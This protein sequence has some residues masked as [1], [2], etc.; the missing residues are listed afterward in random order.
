MLKYEYGKMM[1]DCTSLKIGGP[2]FCWFEP[3]DFKGI[4]EAISVAETNKKALAF[5]GKGTNILARDEG[6]NGVAMRLGRGFN[7]IESEDNG[8]VRVG[9]AVFLSR[10]VKECAELGLMGCEF[11]S[12]IPA[13]FGGALFMNAGVRSIRDSGKRREIKDIIFD[14]DVLDLR[15]KKR[16]TLKRSDIEFSYRSSGLEGVCI[17]GGRIRLEKDRKSA[18]INR[19]DFFMERR[20]GL[21]DL[22]FPSAGSVFRN[23]QDVGPA[24]RLIEGC[25]LKGYRVGKAEFSAAHANIIVNTGG[26][27][28]KDVFDLID[29]AKKRVKKRF[30]IELELEL[31]VI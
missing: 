30:G 9:S 26:A 22:G 2:V 8:L 24:G 20:I 3:E 31:K 21:R 6:F 27:T 14:V 28:S 13:S 11:L 12:G 7:Y 17:L 4:V 19:I 25:G 16:K 29:M 5:F 1:S 18:I 15:D 23:P 10:L